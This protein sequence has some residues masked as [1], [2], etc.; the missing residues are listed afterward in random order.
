MER[1]Q[2]LESEVRFAQESL[3]PGSGR[4]SLLRLDTGILDD[5]APARFLAEKIP[6]ERF[7]RLGHH[8]QAFI[9]AE[10][11]EGVGSH[12]FRGRFVQAIDDIGR[13]LRRR[14]DAVPSFG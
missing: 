7:G 4:Y 11:L 8:H 3:T 2:L 10:L 6:V 14:I 1:W 13:R 9:D 12:G 5:L